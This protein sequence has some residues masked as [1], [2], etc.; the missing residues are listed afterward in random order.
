M[1]K[2]AVE[3]CGSRE[4]YGKPHPMRSQPFRA[5]ARP[6]M[7]ELMRSTQATRLT[8][9]QATCAFLDQHAERLPAVNSSNAR[10]KLDELTA[11]IHQHASDQEA[12][13]LRRMSETRRYQ[14]LRDDLIQHHIGPIVAMAHSVLLN[15]PTLHVHRMPR[16][17]PHAAKLAAEAEGLA[18]AVRPRAAEFVEAGLEADFLD[19]LLAASDAMFTSCVTRVQ[20]RGNRKAATHGVRH[21]LA[22]A[23]TV[24]RVLGR[25][26]DKEAAGDDALVGSWSSIAEPRRLAATSSAKGLAAPRTRASLAAP[27]VKLLVSGDASADP[28]APEDAGSR[29]GFLE[30]FKQLVHRTLGS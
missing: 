30:P 22:A 14:M 20:Q 13:A 24:V 12:Y 9:L 16:G 2:I 4:P 28:Q 3:T 6:T 15:D 10:R 1:P 7:E 5:V 17:N 25:L 11:S 27:K 29:A 18:K 23:R 19:R 8:Q 21:E 26:V